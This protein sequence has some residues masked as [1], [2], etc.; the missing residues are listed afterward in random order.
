MKR[1]SFALALALAAAAV[2]AAP[3]SQR[4][5]EKLLD[6]M[7]AQKIVDQMIPAMLEQVREMAD[8]MLAEENASQ[9]E[10]ERARRL[11]AKQEAELRDTLAW[12]KLEP[13]YTRV[14]ADTLT[15]QEV[16]AMTAFYDSPEGRGVMRKLPEIMRRSMIEMRPMMQASMQKMMR[17]IESEFGPPAK[18]GK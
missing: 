13:I 4:Q 7:E 1:L 5:V 18:R 16:E 10:R 12:A 17:D 2:F 6:T 8:Q 3:P 11:L 14:Y 15:D 9:A